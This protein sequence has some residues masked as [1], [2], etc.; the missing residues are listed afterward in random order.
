MDNLREGE[1]G[2][3]GR[4]TSLVSRHTS[5]HRRDGRR[6]GT[7][8]SVGKRITDGG[9]GLQR[10]PDKGGVPNSRD[11]AS[12]DLHNLDYRRGESGA[13]SLGHLFQSLSEELESTSLGLYV[14]RQ[15]DARRRETFL[16][17]VNRP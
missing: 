6:D 13:C 1:K 15:I 3:E 4:Y 12:N 14:S 17:Y 8:F 2:L 10:R 9:Q 11:N 16:A 5:Q 7:F